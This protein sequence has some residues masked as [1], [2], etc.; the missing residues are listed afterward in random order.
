MELPI[1]ANPDLWIIEQ[2]ALPLAA[3]L[4]PFWARNAG[5]TA[6]DRNSPIQL[7]PG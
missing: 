1:P 6:Y 5:E 2:P 3:D 7:D 4:P